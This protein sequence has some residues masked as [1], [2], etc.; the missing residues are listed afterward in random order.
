MHLRRQVTGR[1]DRAGSADR[2][3]PRPRS[4]RPERIAPS[5]PIAPKRISAPATSQPG[6]G[7]L[8]VRRPARPPTRGRP[9]EDQAEA[10]A[11][12]HRYGAAS[13]G[14]LHVARVHLDGQAQVAA[15][16]AVRAEVG[17]APARRALPSSPGRRA[18]PGRRSSRPWSGASTLSGSSTLTWPNFIV[19]RDRLVLA[20]E[21]ERAQ[22]QGGG[23]DVKS[24]RSATAAMVCGR[25]ELL[26]TSPPKRSAPVETTRP[27]VASTARTIS[28]RARPNQA[29]TSSPSAIVASAAAKY[30]GHRHADP[31]QVEHGEHAHH[32]HDAEEGDPAELR[33]LPR[34]LRR[35]RRRGRR[36]F[37]AGATGR[38][39]GVPPLGPRA[40]RRERRPV[41]AGRRAEL[42]R[43]RPQLR[44]GRCVRA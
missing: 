39:A 20:G 25:Y 40:V 22:V 27:S 41:A 9:Q 7:R 33:A 43:L 42:R 24:Y 8:H 10:R 4:R 21:V 29:P 37:G 12:R 35:P 5:S 19:D 23:A 36:L 34:R 44:L 38:A 30:A 15:A 31:G 13:S 16:L 26:A 32:D 14:H 11:T 3:A 1:L 17:D 18:A 28:P 6:A 2:R